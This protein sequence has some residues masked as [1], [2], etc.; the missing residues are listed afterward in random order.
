MLSRLLQ[1][2]LHENPQPLPQLLQLFWE[3]NQLSWFLNSFLVKAFC[4]KFNKL[5]I[6]F[7]VENKAKFLPKVNFIAT[8]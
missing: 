8:F 4:S 3:E 2:N 5:L 1:P 7:L 6:C